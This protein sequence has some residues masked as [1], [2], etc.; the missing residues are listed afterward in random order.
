MEV[1]LDTCYFVDLQRKPSVLTEVNSKIGGFGLAVTDITLGEF[2]EGAVL[3][4]E[5]ALLPYFANY[6]LLSTTPEAAWHYGCVRR[7]L[8]QTGQ[9]IGANDLWIAAIALSNGMPVVTRNASEFGR[10]PGL[11]VI[12]Y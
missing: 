7:Y 3:G 10:V 4:S 11:A 12:G 5:A 9:M 1:I 6:R 8:R 2:A